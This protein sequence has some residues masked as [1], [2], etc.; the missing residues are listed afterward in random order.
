MR[1][2]KQSI[3]FDRE[4]FPFFIYKR[5][6]VTRSSHLFVYELPIGYSYIMRRI[7]AEYNAV[8]KATGSISSVVNVKFN[9]PSHNRGFNED[10]YPIGLISSPASRLLASVGTSG[11]FYNNLPATQQNQDAF[12]VAFSAGCLKLSKNLNYLTIYKSRIEIEI[13]GMVIA[14]SSPDDNAPG[15]VDIMLNG[16]LNPELQEKAWG[17]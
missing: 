12:S 1:L 7:S 16:R 5:I 13:S 4:S 8:D 14:S 11:N 10:P 15:Y 2:Q 9:D 17:K 6:K 3:D